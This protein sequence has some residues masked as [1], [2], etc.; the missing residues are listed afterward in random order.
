MTSRL[1]SIIYVRS[2]FLVTFASRIKSGRL[3]EMVGL[4]FV[5]LID[6]PLQFITKIDIFYHINNPCAYTKK[7]N[8]CN[9]GIQETT[10]HLSTIL[11]WL[12]CLQLIPLA[13]VL[14]LPAFCFSPLGA[15][16]AKPSVVF[17]KV[18]PRIRK[19]LYQLQS[20]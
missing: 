19:D 20:S 15:I 17:C 3:F 14:Q 5:L 16:I 11:L 9:W 8:S 2:S 7:N 4:F 1:S 18:N 12:A 6:I 13:P 10:Y